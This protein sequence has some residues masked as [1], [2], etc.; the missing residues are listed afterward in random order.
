MH[1]AITD[2][3]LNELGVVYQGTRSNALDE[4]ITVR[5]FHDCPIPR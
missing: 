5:P 4:R 3:G 2:T 1:L